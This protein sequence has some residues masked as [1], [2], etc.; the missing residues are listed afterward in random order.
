MLSRF[1]IAIDDVT[2]SVK[3]QNPLDVMFGEC[4]DGNMLLSLIKNAKES[5]RNINQGWLHQLGQSGDEA[6]RCDA[7]QTFFNMLQIYMIHKLCN[8]EQF[9]SISPGKMHSILNL[10]GCPRRLKI[11]DGEKYRVRFGPPLSLKKSMCHHFCLSYKTYNSKY[12][13]L[14]TRPSKNNERFLERLKELQ[15]GFD[16]IREAS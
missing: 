14:K 6:E 4:D 5:H 11:R 16:E 10:H 1:E 3:V 12:T 7:R 13:E 15:E 9:E 8:Q 2:D